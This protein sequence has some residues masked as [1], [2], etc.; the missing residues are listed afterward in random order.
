MH[1]EIVRAVARRVDAV[2]GSSPSRVTG[3]H[4]VE[5][6]G[7]V[8]AWEDVDE[9]L[10]G[11]LL[12]EDEVLEQVLDENQAAGLPEIDVSPLQGALLTVLARAV[13]ARRVL[14]VGTLGGYSTVHLA[15]G[16]APGGRV[17]TCELDPRH[18][19][20][21]RRNLERAGV[22]DVVDVRVGPA[23]D[24]LDALVAEGAAPFH[25]VFLDADKQG[26]PD[27]LERALRLVRPGSL[28]VGDNVVRDGR[29]ADAGSDDPAVTG[30]RRFLQ[31]LGE[32]PRLD[33]TAVQTVGAKG[34]DGFA[35][36]VVR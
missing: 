27:Y 12:G 15:R 24:T 36:A 10:A 9:Y 21:A 25:L 1:P 28:I 31:A 35:I 33:A 20:V 23:L 32:D 19:E 29:V 17:V 14:E 5:Q 8:S 6:H 3:A 16:L 13:A 11:T 22:A 26:N 18:A 34:W 30:A 2:T 7:A 4:R